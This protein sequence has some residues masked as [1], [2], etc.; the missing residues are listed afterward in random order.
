[1]F[2]EERILKVEAITVTH[3]L[4]STYEFSIKVCAN[5]QQLETHTCLFHIGAGLNHASETF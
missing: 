1:M 2:A 5:T 4:Q 3:L